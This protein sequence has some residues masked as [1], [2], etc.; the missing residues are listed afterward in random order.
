MSREGVTMLREG[1]M[2]LQ[3]PNFAS[4]NTFQNQVKQYQKILQQEKTNLLHVYIFI[5]TCP[6]RPD[7]CKQIASFL[8]KLSE[9]LQCF[10]RLLEDSYPTSISTCY[11]LV[12]MSLQNTD[13]YI[14]NL[15]KLLSQ[16]RMEHLSSLKQLNKYQQH[17]QH[18]F[19]L[20]TSAYTQIL[21]NVPVLL[22]H[23]RF[24]ERKM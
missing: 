5:D 18:T 10:C 23:I 13:E 24:L 17:I 1:A 14:K 22:D 6:I 11:M 21:E 2:S 15:I 20:L 12:V 16:V 8:H 7:H 3:Q 19:E 9:P 4:A